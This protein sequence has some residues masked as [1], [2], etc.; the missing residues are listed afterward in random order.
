MAANKSNRPG[1]QA[2]KPIR[3]VGALGVS[4]L[5]FWV[6]LGFWPVQ[7]FFY[8]IMLAAFFVTEIPIL[9]SLLEGPSLNFFLI[10]WIM[11][12]TSG[13]LLMLIGGVAFASIGINYLGGERGG[14]KHA[15]FLLS[16]IGYTIPFLGFAPWLIP[17]LL[18]VA[19]HPE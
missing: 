9:G 2:G 8:F 11:I 6:A 19:R 5:M 7:I 13:V 3:K 16:L 4:R 15:L 14:L 18:Y 1:L 17:W 12:A 10:G